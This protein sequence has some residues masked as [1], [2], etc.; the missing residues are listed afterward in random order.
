VN[1][2]R[3]GATERLYVPP[4]EHPPEPKNVVRQ[5]ARDRARLLGGLLVVVLTSIAGRGTWLAL[6]PVD[7]VVE[8]GN[9]LRYDEIVM[10]ADRGEVFDR[11]GR[12]MAVTVDTPSIAV[13]P[14]LIPAERRDDLA[15]T[16][17][18]ILDRPRD[19]ILEK[20]L[21]KGSGADA[22]PGS[23]HYAKLASLVHPSVAAK[24]EDL[25]EPAVWSHRDPHRYYP[26]ETLGSQLLGFVD[27]SGKG[28]VGVEEAL[29][30]ELRGGTFVV[31]RRRDRKGIDVDRP[32]AV[33]RLANHGR[34][35]HLTID[36]QIQHI[37][38]Q[39]LAGVVTVSAPVATS[40]LVV[41][42]KTG[43]VL[44]MANY[45]T[46]NPNNVGDVPDGRKNHIVA[47]AIE[48]GSVFKP[49]TM[50]AALEEKLVTPESKIDCESGLWVIGRSRIRD[51]HPHGVVP[52]AEVMKYS[53]NIGSAKLAFKVG[54]KKFID[55]LH[56]FGFGSR[57][58][59]P[60][61]GERL[62]RIRDPELIK[63][64]ELAT[65]AFGQGTTATPLQLAMGIA[66][67]AND[68]VRMKPR[69]VSHVVDAHGV[70]EW[71]QPPTPVARPISAET[72]Q[73]VRDQMVLVTEDGGTGTRARVAGYKVGGK[74]GTAQKVKGGRYSE[75]RISSFVG[76]I[77]ADDPVLTIVVIV[78]EPTQGSKYGGIAAAPAWSQIAE[79]SLRYLG[80]QPNPE[81]LAEAK[82]AKPKALVAAPPTTTP[83][84]PLHLAWD[85]GGWNMPDLKG[86]PMREVL[87]GLQGSGL[88]LDLHGSGRAVSQQPPVGARIPPGSEISVVFQ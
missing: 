42:V 2:T 7:R 9:E 46:F 52:L 78:D 31:Q 44:A 13:D 33:D 15:T 10:P 54:A 16:L 29:D 6:R 21:R 79:Q 1:R 64:I 51:D 59:I 19:E 14:S 76:F 82:P 62:G 58:G 70:T 50:A 12:R 71:A 84:E 68:G 39:A 47:D 8:R 81:L 24:I 34:D 30:S 25:H 43:D 77:P 69:L 23:A 3:R 48:P 20:L 49:F 35:L 26:E 55:Y 88:R 41:D 17:S 73:I 37:A 87:A 61:P 38:E 18:G 27:A 40:A 80:V 86:R 28:Q 72:A 75:A 67:I 56:G 63:P 74:T 57:T 5:R 11:N 83:A 66:A 45:P 4:V 65:T 85:G 32:A 36:R 60:L 53:S 22:A